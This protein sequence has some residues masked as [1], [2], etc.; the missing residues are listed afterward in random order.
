MA[1]D[2]VFMDTEYVQGMVN[3]FK[4]LSTVCQTISSTLDA[5]KMVLKLTAF[6][7]G[8]GAAA[9]RVVDQ[10]QKAVKKLAEEFKELSGD[11]D[12]ALRAFRDGDTTGSKRFQ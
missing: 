1:D 10:L 6:F 7:G 2:A 5:I 9:E 3:K 8:I 11:V 12:G 4:T